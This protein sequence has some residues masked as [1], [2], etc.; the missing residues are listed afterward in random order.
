MDSPIFSTGAVS[1]AEEYWTPPEN[2]SVEIRVDSR[3]LRD[4]NEHVS[5]S[6]R[7][8]D[9]CSVTRYRNCHTFAHKK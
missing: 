9:M 6:V 2:L 8:T 5:A 1:I 3:C 7:S 4:A